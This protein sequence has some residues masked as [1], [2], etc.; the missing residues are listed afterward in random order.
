M[1]STPENYT[2][3]YAKLSIEQ[4][5]HLH[6]IFYDLKVHIKNIFEGKDGF[7][8]Y[9]FRDYVDSKMY[10]SCDTEENIKSLE[11]F[12]HEAMEKTSKEDLFD[13]IIDKMHEDEFVPSSK[14]S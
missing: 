1:K 12:V 4:Q 13:Y 6:D 3:A 9:V 2:K 8:A 14:H 10:L 11:H 7:N 5:T